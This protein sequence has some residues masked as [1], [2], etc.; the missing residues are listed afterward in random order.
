MA[1]YLGAQEALPLKPCRYAVAISWDNTVG[2]P[3]DVDLQAIVVDSRGSIIDAVYYNNLKA[4]RCMTH[5]GDEQTGE[6]AGYDEVIWVGL[7]RLPENVMMV[8][9]VIATHTGHLRDVKNGMIHILE[10]R[11][12]NEV[13][14]F[15]M[16]N[17]VEEVDMVAAMIRSGEG[18]S[19]NVIEE[20]AQDGRH[21]IDILEPC[22]GNYIR[23]V[24]PGAPRR[25]KVAFAMEK[26]AVFDLPR[27]NEMAG[28]SACLGWDTMG[29]DG[30]DLDVSAVLFDGQGSVVDAVF[31]GNLEGSGLKHSGDNLTGDGDGDDEQIECN[32]AAIPEAVQQVFFVVNM[33]SRG[34]TFERVQNAY[35]RIVDSSQNELARYTLSEGQA[36][37]GLIIARLFRE[38]DGRWGFQAIGSFARG[39]T[40]KD[41]IR[42]IMP[43]L[44]QGLR[45]LQF[46]TQSTMDFSGA[47]PGGYG[48]PPAGRPQVQVAPPGG[49][50]RKSKKDCSLQ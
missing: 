20:P 22:I 25:M 8:I 10:E 2:A 48:A 12:N 4:L 39:N 6:K 18:W 26:G 14:R 31:F 24:I 1:R 17:S 33:Y 13:A 27:S 5:S 3:V 43:F 36:Q 30:V 23:K 40:Y 7:P 46:R 45:D 11:P 50:K 34:M 28:I 35:C 16:E 41:S 42:D 19:M 32:L 47:A 44:S 29:D 21:F 49:D 9:F 37:S 38:V 15:A